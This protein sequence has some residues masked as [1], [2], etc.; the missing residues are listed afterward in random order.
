MN[1]FRGETNHRRLQLAI[2][3]GAVRVIGGEVEGW[4]EKIVGAVLVGHAK[5]VMLNLL[6][7]ERAETG[8][9]KPCS[10]TIPHT[11]NH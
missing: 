2:D 10:E 8:R 5:D 7:R 11:L 4:R 1:R 3:D 9:T 6:G